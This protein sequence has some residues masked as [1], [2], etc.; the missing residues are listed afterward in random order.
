MA[1]APDSYVGYGNLG[2]TYLYE[3]QLT[4]ALPL[5]EQSVRIESTSDNTSNLATLYFDLRR[6]ADSARTNEKAIALNSSPYD[7]WG[8]LGDS[9]Y[10]SPGERSKS[11]SAYRSAIVLAN[12]KL[13]VNPRDATTLSYLAQYNAMIGQA[14]A[15]T[16]NINRALTLSPNDQYVLFEAALVFN[17]LNKPEMAL[18]YLEKAVA[19]GYPANTLLDTPNIDNLHSHPRF[20]KLVGSI[21]EE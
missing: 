12:K 18:D 20:R 9:Y 14:N 11:F 10:W 21:P 13:N 17:Q 4:K 16:E 2:N 8:N 19:A 6:F 5:L 15:A 7:I 1:L 3:G